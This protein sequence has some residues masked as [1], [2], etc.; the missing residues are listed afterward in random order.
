MKIGILIWQLDIK[1][2]TQRQALELARNLLRDGHKVIIYT[3]I[4]DKERSYPGLC[5]GLDIRC[6]KLHKNA[7]KADCPA[8]DLEYLYKYFIFFTG[9]KHRQLLDIVDTDLDVL[10]PHD[11]GVYVT[12]GLWQRKYDKPVVWMMNDLP[13]FKWNLKSIPKT[14]GYYIR[15]EYRRFI[16]RFEE[17][18]VL[19]SINQ[20]G[21]KKNFNRES[22]IVRSGLN[23]EWF[24]FSKRTHKDVVTILMTSV[25]Y[26]HRK[27]EDGVRALKILLDRGHNIFIEHIGDLKQNLKYTR[28]IFKLIDQ[29]NLQERFK[30]NG[31]VSA[32]ELLKFY[33]NSDAYLFPN[34][35][36]TWGLSVFEAMACGIP[37]VL[38]YGCGASE[39]LKDQENA[40]IVRPDSPGELARA[41]E[42]LI[43]HKE[44]S[45]K[46]AENARKFVEDNISWRFYS[47]EMLDIFEKYVK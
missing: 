15:P 44:L 10:N 23:A 13:L 29:L 32:P 41:V 9:K 6:V 28:K 8:T 40:M 25:L 11:Y 12:A 34:S 14:I 47:E 33:E 36:Q 19:D 46:I 42:E 17:I 27:V 45:E 21:V 20:K 3:Y 38:T 37:V 1:G 7:D 2:G 30:F 43:L 24:K 22:K 5:E 4:F 31:S 39:V 26:P 35:P 16:Q 18:V